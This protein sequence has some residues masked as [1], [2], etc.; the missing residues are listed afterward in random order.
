LNNL[1]F[2]SLFKIWRYFE[3][4]FIKNIYS[5][6]ITCP[7][8]LEAVGIRISVRNVRDYNNFLL[9]FHLTVISLI[10]IFLLI[11]LI[12]CYHICYFQYYYEVILVQYLLYTGISYMHLSY[13]FVL[14]SFTF[15][16]F[17]CAGS[18]IVSCSC[19]VS[20]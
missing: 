3:A 11:W 1:K 2:H 10:W 13:M 15:Y 7:S 19:W 12:G 6:F 14:F 20:T 16:L 4:L 5:S 8:L 9:H 18:V 17:D